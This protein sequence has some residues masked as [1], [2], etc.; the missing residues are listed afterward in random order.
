V[1]C[2]GESLRSGLSMRHEGKPP[3]RVSNGGADY[4]G[5]SMASSA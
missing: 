4:I 1:R 2:P 5:S 3:A